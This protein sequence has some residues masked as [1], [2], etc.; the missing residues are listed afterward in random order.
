[1]Q[2][3]AILGRQPELGIAELE[4]VY[5]DNSIDVMN[6]S[7]A[8]M[9][10]VPVKPDDLKRLGGSIKLA[11]VLSIQD[12]TD[13]RSLERYL[14]KS[15]PEHLKYVPDGKLHLGLSVFGLNVRV[16]D[17]NATALR[18]KKI[19][20]NHGRSVRVV[21]NKSTALNSAQ[22]LHNK[23]AADH[24][25]ELIFVRNGG[26]TVLAQT[27]AEQ[28][29][30]A[31]AARDQVRPARD[32]RVGMLP[33]KLAQIMVNLAI[34]RWLLEDGK[35][36]AVL[37]PFCGTGVVLQE[38]LLMDYVVSGT[39]LSDKMIDYSKKNLEWLSAKFHIPIANSHLEQ[40][41]ATSH[42][43]NTPIDA[44]V[45]ETYLGQPFNTPP[46][47]DKLSEVRNTCDTI[48]SKFLENLANQIQSGTTLCLAIPAWRDN[49]GRFSTLQL[50][51][52]LV[53]LGYEKV[54]L[55]HVVLNNI[56]YYRPDQVV[57]RELLILKKL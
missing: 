30:D 6:G 19:I 40:G 41:D 37:D 48:I 3:I 2:F 34:G 26:K 20:R 52:K 46:S 36:I 1:M 22:V 57:A 43:W 24:G 38:A 15:V 21:P 11:K 45:S 53:Q 42:R 23:L 29:I 25:W 27:I 31:Y 56:L 44:V 50:N 9:L 47:P 33:P 5:G 54:R 7:D 8:V 14:T 16:D 32:A 17:I 55:K 28:D 51:K 12:S 35:K 4:R 18:L 13:W 10:D 49:S 39:D